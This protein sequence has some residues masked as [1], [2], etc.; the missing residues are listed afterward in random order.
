MNEIIIQIVVC[1]LQSGT[2]HSTHPVPQMQKT[3][4]I[5]C[6]SFQQEKKVI[7]NAHNLVNEIGHSYHI[8]IISNNDRQYIFEGLGTTGI[9]LL[10]KTSHLAK[11]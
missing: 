8:F 6:G 5:F 1:N 7:R 11:V 9:T 3:L 2:V 10:C 4:K